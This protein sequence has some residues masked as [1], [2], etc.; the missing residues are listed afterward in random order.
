MNK[1]VSLLSVIA[2]T[3]VSAETT[4]HININGPSLSK[5]P[6]CS[7]CFPIVK[8]PAMLLLTVFGA[9][10]QQSELD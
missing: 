4:G 1:P 9:V 2:A 8:I 3:L 7:V 5:I 10:F 6:D